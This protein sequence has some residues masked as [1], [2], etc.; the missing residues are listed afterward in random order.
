MKLLKLKFL[1]NKKARLITLLSCVVATLSVTLIVSTV[2]WFSAIE[3]I[4]PND[5]L[6][7]A[8]L[9]SYFDHIDNPPDETVYPHGSASNP[10]VITRPVHYYNLVRLQ[11]GGEYGFNKDTYFQ[12][13]KTNIDGTGNTE[14][15]FYEY[16]DDG[17]IQEGEYT[18]YLNMT[19]YSGS[20]ALAPI[21]SPR[22]PF[23]G[24]IQGNNLTVQNLNVTGSGLSDIGIFGYVTINASVHNLYFE[25]PKINANGANATAAGSIGHASHATH[26]YIGYLAGHVYNPNV[27][28]HVYLN[29]CVLYNTVGN[30]YEM[31]NTYGYF[32]HTDEPLQST[33][34]SSSYT[35]QLVAANA[36]EALEYS[37]S[38]G[39]SN[40]LARRYT[41]EVGSGNFSGAVSS[42]NTA[43]PVYTIGQKTST[44]PYSLSSI[45]YSSGDRGK[46]QYIR[47]IKNVS[48]ENRYVEINDIEQENILTD[49]PQYIEYG[50]DQYGNPLEPIDHS[51]DP[52]YDFYGM[53][54]GS[55]IFCDKTYTTDPVTGEQTEHCQW[56]YAEVSADLTKPSTGAVSLNCFTISYEQTVNNVTKKY[57]LKYLAGSNGE[58]DTLVPEEWASSTPPQE[59]KYYFCFKTTFG[60]NG[61]SRFTECGT[62]AEY[63]IY[64]PVGKKYVC[65]YSPQNVHSTDPVLDAN[66]VHTPIFVPEEG[67]TVAN[68]KKHMPMK[69]TIAGPKTQIS[70]DSFDNKE[71]G[72][73]RN[74]NDD[75]DSNAG[76]TAGPY[77]GA[78]QGSNITHQFGIFGGH[79]MTA[80][81]TGGFF[82]I[83]DYLE[84]QTTTLN[85]AINYRL[86]S[87][88]NE[89]TDMSTLVIAGFKG[90]Q[91]NTY[92]LDYA[93]STQLQ[94][95]RGVLQV[96][97]VRD[98]S[99]Y[100]L[101]ET[102][103]VAKLVLKHIEG[104]NSIFTLFDGSGYIT[105]PAGG[106]IFTGG[107]NTK[108]YLRTYDY[109]YI[110]EEGHENRIPY[111]QWKFAAYVQSGYYTRYR[112]QNVGN[113]DRYLCYNIG[114]N[115]FATYSLQEYIN[116][117][118]EK[119]LTVTGFDNN[120]VNDDP[121]T[122]YPNNHC[123]FYIYKQ[124]YGQTI[125]NVHFTVAKKVDVL[126]TTTYPFKLVNYYNLLGSDQNNSPTD[127]TKYTNFTI[128][129]S[130]NVY[131][132]TQQS[133]VQY[134]DSLI[135]V[136]KRVNLISE[137]HAG[138]TVMIAAK[139]GSGSGNA[140][141]YFMSS[142]ATNYRNRSSSVSFTPP[143]VKEQ[144][145]PTNA[146]RFTLSK[147]DRGWRFDTGSGFLYACSSSQNYLRT[148]SS[149]DAN[150]N[151]DWSIS[152]T[153]DGNATIRATG[154]Y[155]RNL[156]RYYAQSSWWGGG[157]GYFSCFSSTSGYNIQLYK[158][159][160]SSADRATYVGDL[161]NNFEP[162][163][164][165]AVGPNIDYH[166]DYMQMNGAP[167]AIV[168]PTVGQRYYPSVNFKNAITLMIDNNG[169]RDLGTLTFECTSTSTNPYFKLPN[170]TED[171]VAAGAV[172]TSPTNDAHSY[173]LNINAM[174]I[175]SL[176]Y[177]YIKGVGDAVEP[178][179]FCTAD[180]PKMTKYLVVLGAA[181]D[182]HITNVTFTFNSVPGNIGYG[183]RVDYRSAT[184]DSSTG[185]YTGSV[186]GG[187][188]VEYSALSIYYDIK[189]TGQML[190]I[191]VAFTAGTNGNPGV[192][193][194]TIDTTKALL[195]ADL[196][197]NLFKYDNNLSELVVVV[198]GVATT[199][200][201]GSVTVT[202]PA[203]STPSP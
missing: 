33:S 106:G 167:T 72:D 127:Y 183:G 176:A 133:Q 21:G 99:G 79:K 43:N 126:G 58:Y 34:D 49:K 13:G 60:S 24:Q 160:Q 143:Y 96:K 138:D 116:K 203:N 145:V 195:T 88:S 26:V 180:D 168:D 50:T 125:Q 200:Y 115:C 174:N 47:Y 202:I 166:S 147:S 107:S 69:F 155:S 175:G 94:N 196:D 75:F 158:L 56:K 82:T 20:N 62:E 136:W 40:P 67:I 90:E 132:D 23:E 76:R 123:W 139:T 185:A 187:N 157:S 35:S 134:F 103:G 57:F 173:L 198:D 141:H 9:T 17:V 12:F 53:S 193:T 25:S 190:D 121:V 4:K 87:N 19:Y 30:E 64:S 154:N 113:P 188:Q 65:T 146:A 14:P 112:F 77:K 73:G 105:F 102:T 59:D 194:V 78:L 32:G 151:A 163:R 95:N 3:T 51:N 153:T 191:K 129:P 36:Y 92:S 122:G 27:F 192:Y 81:C 171:I 66:L 100:V 38:T 8:I 22:H 85:N 178:Y 109:D 6:D 37:Y 197:V 172:D 159:S 5:N 161:I 118:A 46:T 42:D 84:E 1:R 104:S 144:N 162:F 48:G 201:T 128:N 199:Y 169:S 28:D 97:E 124:Q 15:L 44:Q 83:G 55:Y 11:E 86:T 31:I 114:S 2:S 41:S 117:A 80:S 181:S 150:G 177:A 68:G 71:T 39:Y 189:L 29:N 70:Y 61:A 91:T 93:M 10:Y 130:F 120:N 182:V 184:Y 140:T 119:G 98:S 135:E 156:M 16:N 137:L 18:P 89:I 108:N 111:S 186:A 63:Y 148:E 164:M 152:I 54:D 110:H 131:F 149:P 74:V 45:G 142:Q 165:D 101:N 52:T 170:E 179:E 7:G